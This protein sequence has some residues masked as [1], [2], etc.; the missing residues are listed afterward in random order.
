[1]NKLMIENNDDKII[2]I[3]TVYQEESQEEKYL[4]RK[5][6]FRYNEVLSKPEYKLISQPI[7]EYNEVD[8]MALNSLYRE[9]RNSKI[10]TSK[11]NLANIIKSDFCPTY[12]PFHDYLNG[13]PEWDQLSD[14]ILELANTI[15]TTDDEYW[16]RMLKKWL[17]ALVGSLLD[18]KTYPLNK[19]G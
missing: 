15:K 5:Y 1:M 6:E 8:E 7:S 4:K 16:Q 19:S 17:V 2:D 12:N 10:K 14:H 13:L 3:S 18:D 11:D 9:L